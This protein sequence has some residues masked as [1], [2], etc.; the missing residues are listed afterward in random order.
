MDAMAAAS[1][2]A[3]AVGGGEVSWVLGAGK[4]IDGDEGVM[5]DGEKRW[6]RCKY[7]V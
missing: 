2:R 7:D 5:M 3:E 6:V 1:P 4:S